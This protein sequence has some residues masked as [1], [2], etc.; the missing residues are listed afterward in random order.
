M[1]QPS[2]WSVLGSGQ[3]VNPTGIVADTG[4]IV[5]VADY[6]SGTV[7]SKAG[8]NATTIAELRLLPRGRSRP[9]QLSL[10]CRCQDQRQSRRDDLFDVAGSGI[11]ERIE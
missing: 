3:L 7:V 1:F 11:S 2:C 10:L 8:G 5:Y 4:G 6:G 9:D